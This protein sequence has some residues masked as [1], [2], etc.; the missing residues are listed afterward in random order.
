MNIV[1][2]GNPE[3]AANCLDALVKS[4][5]NI[6]AVV[7]NPAKK[8]GRGQKLV[9]T[10]VFKFADQ[11]HLNI[12]EMP[13]LNDIEKKEQLIELNADIFVVVA[14]RILP[15]DIINIPKK[16]CINLH[17]SL[18]PKYRGAAP[19]QWSLI[20]GEK[21]CGLTT[22]L[23]QPKIDTGQI[24]LQKS[25]S[26]NNNDDYGLLSYRMSYM[27]GDLLVETLDKFQDGEIIPSEQ[28]LDG[29]SYAPKITS[30]ICNI[31]CSRS[32]IDIHNLIRGLSPIPSARTIL[33]HKIVK[34]FKTEL[35]DG[36]SEHQFGSII[37]NNNFIIQTGSGQ[38]KVLELQIEGKKRMATYD[39][40]RGTSIIPNT[41][42]G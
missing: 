15:K 20:N 5:H 3:F 14:Y 16:G 8:A 12:I 39:Y 33:N 42:L 26:I 21:T 30:E 22:F 41:K 2:M 19:I 36:N 28:S 37:D 1:F 29:V 4:K 6:L 23:I 10:Q 17:G 7:T 13:N 34:I 9:Q 27:G 18:L 25:V 32:A 24:L 35:I 11:L 40:L 38:L 31:D